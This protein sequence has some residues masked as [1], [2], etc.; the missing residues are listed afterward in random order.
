MDTQMR[1]VAI[2]V[3]NRTREV[4]L[5]SVSPLI[6]DIHHNTVV[7]AARVG[8][9]FA[10]RGKVWTITIEMNWLVQGFQTKDNQPKIL[11]TLG[12]SLMVA[13]IGTGEA[14]LL[15]AYHKRTEVERPHQIWET[16]TTRSDLQTKKSSL[17]ISRLP[18]DIIH[19]ESMK[20]QKLMKK[21]IQE[22]MKKTIRLWDRDLTEADVMEPMIDTARIESD[23][24][25]TLELIRTWR[26]SIQP[27]WS[28]PVGNRIVLMEYWE[29]RV[30]ALL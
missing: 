26:D 21:C 13:M 7:V 29:K 20:N 17:A 27:S 14:V 28:N 11:R 3:Q 19:Q 16:R 1:E 18:N 4:L 6:I 22:E 30:W 10:K 12:I 23:S 5:T 9:A 24:N 25:M 2:F 8:I 15:F